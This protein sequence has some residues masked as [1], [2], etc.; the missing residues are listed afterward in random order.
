MA[1]QA[2]SQPAAA[3]SVAE[4]AAEPSMPL[5]LAFSPYLLLTVLI[6]SVE[7]IP[8]LGEPLAAIRFGLP[9]PAL[10]TGYGVVTAATEA[11]SGFSPLTHPGT[12]LLVSSIIAFIVFR[13]R[14]DIPGGRIDEI[15]VDTLKTSIPTI[16][17]LMAFVPLALVLEGAGMVL[18]LAI[19]LA[20]VAPPSI[21]ALLSPLIGAFGGFLTGSNLSANILF[22][23]LQWQASVALGLNPAFIVAAQTAGAAIGSSIA[24]S[25]VLLGLGAVG[26]SGQTGNTIRAMLPFVALAVLAIAVVT[27]AGNWM[28]PVSGD[29][30]G[31]GG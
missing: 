21:Y 8:A 6:M 26:A 3:A 7:L 18:E 2:P 19:G 12:F 16:M 5:W 17:A 23:P 9:F 24:I 13:L 10:E 28:F 14:G 1:R 4:D 25:A 11:Y 22:G 15:S 20:Q 30:S 31:T 27:L 29:A